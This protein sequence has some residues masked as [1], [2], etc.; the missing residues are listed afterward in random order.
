[1]YC[2]KVI[3]IL[4]FVCLLVSLVACFLGTLSKQWW[5]GDFEAIVPFYNVSKIPNGYRA[6]LLFDV[7]FGLR[8]ICW[9]MEQVQQNES[10]AQPFFSSMTKCISKL[11]E[12][13]VMRE[14][15]EAN[16]KRKF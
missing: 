3:S 4:V 1:M 9:G 10:L 16:M 6:H 11:P 14:I 8:S 5:C 15:V 13:P 12:D 2:Y 7:R